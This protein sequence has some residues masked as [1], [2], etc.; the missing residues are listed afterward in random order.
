[1]GRIVS[2]FLLICHFSLIF[3]LAVLCSIL[4]FRTRDE[5]LSGFL[6]LIYPLFFHTF[7]V[8]IYYLYGDELGRA[9]GNLV[10][11]ASLLALVLISLTVPLVV[12]GTSSYLLSILDLP[13]KGARRG[14]RIIFVFTLLFFLLG[15]YITVYLHSEDWEIGLSRALNELFLYGSLYL[16]LPAIAATVYLRRRQ[17][18]EKRQLLKHITIS[19]YPMIVFSVLD[20]LFFASSPYKLVYLSYFTFSL[21][22]YFYIARHYVRKYEPELQELPVAEFCRAYSISQREEEVVPLLIEGKSNRE[23]S[24]TLYI[25]LNTVKSHIRNIYRKLAVSNRFQLLV[26]IRNHPEG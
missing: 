1:M 24:E 8:L 23:I 9:L 12:Y 14:R 2:E 22:V 3:S 7:V 5:Y 18:P 25:S 4:F 15:L 17:D 11:A 13:E 21:L 6:R 19:F 10:P 26:K 20:L 16:V